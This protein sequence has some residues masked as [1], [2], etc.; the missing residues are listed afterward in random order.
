VGF[1]TP[2]TTTV[3]VLAFPFASIVKIT[4]VRGFDTRDSGIEVRLL[5]LWR[6]IGE[7]WPVRGRVRSRKMLTS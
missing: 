2:P 7:D 6:L 4:S 5:G 3:S 1:D